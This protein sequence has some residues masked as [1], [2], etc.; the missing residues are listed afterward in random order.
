MDSLNSC[1]DLF[2]SIAVHRKFVLL[3]F[4]FQIDKHLLREI[5]FSERDINRLYLE[6][7]INLLEQH[8]L[9]M[10]VFK[11]EEKPIIEKFSNR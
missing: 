10:D 1:R 6:L 5:G 8:E 2:E 9:Y 7:K 4:L 11:N 3:I